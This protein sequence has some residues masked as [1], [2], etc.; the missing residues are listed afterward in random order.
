MLSL[1]Y[2]CNVIYA[3]QIAAKM[4]LKLTRVNGPLACFG[5]LS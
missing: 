3:P 2:T 4:A 5:F 1:V